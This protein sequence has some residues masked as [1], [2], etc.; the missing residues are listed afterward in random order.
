MRKPF[1]TLGLFALC[2]A[3]KADP[4][5]SYIAPNFGGYFVSETRNTSPTQQS[6]VEGIRYTFGADFAA[7]RH[8]VSAHLNFGF[9]SYIDFAGQFRIFDHSL[10][11]GEGGGTFMYGLGHGLSYSPGIVENQAFVDLSVILFVRALFDTEKD[12]G[13]YLEGN[14]EVVYYREL[15]TNADVDNRISH[16]FQVAIGIPFASSW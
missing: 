14:Y 12:W 4:L 9:G 1:L 10:M 16:R 2:T 7:L 15:M 8:N 11:P 6:T 5:E 3:A 13:L